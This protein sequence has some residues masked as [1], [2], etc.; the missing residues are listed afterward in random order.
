MSTYRQYRREEEEVNLEC[1]PV[2]DNTIAFQMI[3]QLPDQP[4][5]AVTPAPLRNILNRPRCFDMSTASV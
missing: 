2:E 1:G 3:P 4:R 5:V